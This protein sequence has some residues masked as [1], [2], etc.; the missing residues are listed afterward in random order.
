[1]LPT[2]GHNIERVGRNRIHS[3]VRTIHNKFNTFGNR[4]ELPNN[5]LVTNKIIMMSHMLLKLFG[6]VYIIIIRIIT[7][8][9]IFS[10]NHIFDITD[11]FDLFIRIERIRIRSI[12]LHNNASLSF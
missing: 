3:M 9:N 1:M 11:A 10:C 5:E 8:R 7:N 6:T 4:A 2:V 12:F